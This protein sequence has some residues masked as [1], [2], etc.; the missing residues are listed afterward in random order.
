M[1]QT[2]AQTLIDIGIIT[3]L[4]AGLLY[5]IALLDLLP[6]RWSNIAFMFFGPIFVVSVFG[7]RAFYARA[8]DTATNDIA[9][10][11]LVLAGTA[12][13]L[14]ATMQMS[15]YT[16]IPDYHRAALEPDAATWDAI[17]RGVS[18]T[19]L[20][21]DFA[22]DMFVSFGVIALGWQM[23]RHPRVPTLLGVAGMLIGAGGIAVNTITFPENSGIAGLIDPAPAFGVWF[24]LAWL[25]LVF[26]RTWRPE[27]VPV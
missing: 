10:L 26:L 2:K 21:L 4:V 22:F 12:F 5:P 3:G 19:Q 17:L 7:L 25:P 11:L 20:G 18:T 8:R 15:I 6:G 23:V 9:C 1:S 13:A 14:M 27:G 16:A 24:G